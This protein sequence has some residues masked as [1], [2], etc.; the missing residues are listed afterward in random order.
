MDKT[1]LTKFYPNGEVTVVW[2]PAKCWHSR[3]CARNLPKVFQ[4]GERPW[5][6]V[7]NGTSDEIIETVHKCPSGALSMKADEK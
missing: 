2:Q 6:K 7:S 5:V 1:N 4:P 3:N